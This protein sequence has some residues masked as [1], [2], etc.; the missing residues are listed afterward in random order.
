MSGDLSELSVM[1]VDDDDFM[2]E[3][4]SELLR[5]MDVAEVVPVTDGW[6]ALAL[7]A[8]A[9]ATM[10]P[11]LRSV[12]SVVGQLLPEAAAALGVRP[13]IPVVAGLPDLHT[14]GLGAG[15]ARCKP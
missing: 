4:V 2:L 5:Q 7:V 10:L 6:S 9:W 11:P 13:G 3:V 8:A 12:R 1:V 14:A 15:A